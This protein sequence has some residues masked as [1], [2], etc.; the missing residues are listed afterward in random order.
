[1]ERKSLHER[2]AFSRKLIKTCGL[3]SHTQGRSTIQD[4]AICNMACLLAERK[5]GDISSSHPIT[6]DAG[7]RYPATGLGGLPALCI[8]VHVLV[9]VP[10]AGFA[11]NTIIDMNIYGSLITFE[12]QTSVTNDNFIDDFDGNTFR[13]NGT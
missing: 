9:S 1:M 4:S 8:Y 10:G 7:L 2:A 13:T 11:I 6:L 12:D 3:S 5:V